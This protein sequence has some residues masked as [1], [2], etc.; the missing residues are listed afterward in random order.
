MLQAIGFFF[1]EQKAEGFLSFGVSAEWRLAPLDEATH[2]AV[3]V[4]QR[5][6]CGAGVGALT[7][8]SAGCLAAGSD[9]AVETFDQGVEDAYHQFGQVGD[10]FEAGQGPA[11][12]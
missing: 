6:D 11:G 8:G 5:G 9:V 2:P 12:V 1:A 3:G 7:N 4:L 10:G